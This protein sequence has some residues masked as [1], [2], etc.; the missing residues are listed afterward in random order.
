MMSK[1][2]YPAVA[3][4]SLAA[5]MLAGL[6]QGLQG[7]TPPYSFIPLIGIALV[8]SPPLILMAV[9][10]KGSPRTTLTTCVIMAVVG[11]VILVAVAV[12]GG[13]STTVPTLLGVVLPC[14]VAWSLSMLVL[15]E[16]LRPTTP[17]H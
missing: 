13:P 15:R 14:L 6:V 11:L 4:V 16:S 9:K 3:I 17:A 10:Q 8:L 5:F 12:L 7:S 2:K 1:W